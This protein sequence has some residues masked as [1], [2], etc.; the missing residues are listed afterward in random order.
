MYGYTVI[1]G[2]LMFCGWVEGKRVFFLLLFILFIDRMF[3]V[4]QTAS[5][6]ITLVHLSIC[7][8][9]TKFSQDW[10]II[11]PDIVRDDS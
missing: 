2:T 10:I 4:S 7:L 9:I 8:S 3:D 1:C 5:Y 6:E 11:F